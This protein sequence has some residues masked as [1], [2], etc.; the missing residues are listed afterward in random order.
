MP[1][2]A[3][4]AP[5]AIVL[6]LVLLVPLPTAPADPVEGGA[7]R[8]RDA[9]WS[10]TTPADYLLTN[11]VLGGGNAS[12]AS[13]SARITWTT[14]GDFAGNLSSATNVSVAPGGLALTGAPNNLVL[15][16]DFTGPGPWVA[17]GTGNV[18]ASA[19]PPAGRFTAAAGSAPL[20]FDGMNSTAGWIA[21][22]TGPSISLNTTDFIEGAASINVSWSQLAAASYGGA[23][24]T[25]L[26]TGWNFSSYTGLRMRA[27]T[28]EASIAIRVELTDNLSNIW[29][30]TTQ[31]VVPD[32]SAHDF[33]FPPSGLNLLNITNVEVRFRYGIVD[34][35]PH[36][37]NV[38]NLLFY[39]RAQFD[40]S[41]WIAQSVTKPRPTRARAGEVQ[42]TFDLGAAAVENVTAVDLE[43]RLGGFTATLPIPGPLANTTVLDP[44]L[45]VPAPGA[46][47]LSFSLRVQAN[48]LGIAWVD[49]RVDNVDL[50]A[51][52]YW[53]GSYVSTVQDLLTDVRFGTIAANGT[54]GP[55]HGITVHARSG[56]VA[57]PDASWSG[58]TSYPLGAWPAGLPPNR[59]VQLAADLNT[60]GGMQS[61]TLDDLSLTFSWHSVSGT[62]Q[63]LPYTPS[64]VVSRWNNVTWNA[65][66]SPGTAVD[67]LYS[68][69]GVAFNAAVGGLIDAPGTASLWLLAQLTTSNTT[70]TPI[71]HDMT[72]H[73]DTLGPL[74]IITVSPPSWS[75]TADETIQFAATGVDASGNPVPF[76]ANWS[77]DD[78]RGSVSAN[79]TYNPGQAGT[80]TVF[81]SNGTGPVI[82]TAPVTVSPGALFWISIS[83]P[84]ASVVSGSTR[85]FDAYGTDADLNP[86][87]PNP[88]WSTDN[89]GGIITASGQFTACA[90]G[91][92]TVRAEDFPVWQEG[93]VT[94][95][96]GPPATLAVNPL[97]LNL[98]TDEVYLFTATAWDACGNLNTTWVPSWSTSDFFGSI[99]LSGLYRPGEAG[100]QTVTVRSGLLQASA[101]VNVT[102]GNATRIAVSP[103]APLLVTADDTIQFT[104]TGYDA[105]DNPFPFSPVW[106]EDDPHPNGTIDAAG[107]YRPAA[108]GTHTVTARNSNG[109]LVDS[110]AVGVLP[111]AIARL[112]LGPDGGTYPPGS[113]VD[114][115]LSAWDADDNP[116]A[117]TTT[118]WSWTPFVPLCEGCTQTAA[119]LRLRLPATPGPF[120][121][122][123][124]HGPRSVTVT[125]TIGTSALT[126]APLPGLNLTEDQDPVAWDLAAYAG[127]DVTA[128]L[129]WDVAPADPDLATFLSGAFG[130][131][132][133]RVTPKP[134]ASGV[135]TLLLSLR[136]R[137]GDRVNA[138]TTLAITAVNDPPRFD[139]PPACCIQAGTP[140]AFDFSPYVSDIDDTG[141]DLTLTT[142]DTVHASVSGLNVTFAYDNTYLGRTVAV[143]LNVTDGDAW[144]TQAILLNVTEQAPPRRL[145]TLPAVSFPEDSTEVDAFPGTD[146]NGLFSADGALTL[147]FQA[148]A[149]TAV[150]R[151][152]GARL[153]ADLT[154]PADWYGTDVLVIRATDA[155]GCLA[156][157]SAVVVVNPVNDAPRIEPP[158]STLYVRFNQT[159]SFDLEGNITDADNALEELTLTTSDA[160]AW[161][162]G[163]VLTLLYP[164]YTLPPGAFVELPLTLFASDGAALGSAAVTVNISNQS[165]P[166]LTSPFVD[167]FLQENG[168]GGTVVLSAHFDDAEDGPLGLG[169]EVDAGPLGWNLDLLPGQVRLRLSL[170]TGLSGTVPVTITATD[171]S[172]AWARA[173]FRVHIAPVQDPPR[174]LALP[175]IA[176]AA[177]SYTF[178]DL[179]PFVNDS[180]S[181]LA[182]LVVRTSSPYVSAYGLVLLLDYPEGAAAE[183]R[184]T[185][186]L[187]DPDGNEV[188]QVLAVRVTGNVVQGVEIPLA[189]WLGIAGLLS[190]LGAAALL[191]RQPPFQ[192]AFLLAR[193][194]RLLEHRTLRRRADRDEEAH[195]GLI[196]EIREFAAE[197]PE[198][199]AWPLDSD[200]G[201]LLVERHALAILAVL[202]RRA[203][204]KAGSE[205]LGAFL[206]DV[207]DRYGVLL[208]TWSGN[209]EALPGI[210]GMVEGFL[211]ARRYRHGGWE[212]AEKPGER[213]GE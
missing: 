79:G 156:E 84:S 59:Y 184:V 136:S 185:I 149:V 88:A 6:L 154:A 24:R 55:G 150:F 144:A 31:P 142:T 126:I 1:L 176:V 60:T 9:T 145:L 34:G 3:L 74:D 181:D 5:A 23:L 166:R 159:A 94:V 139:P 15:D 91:S 95:T 155:T 36:S 104:A 65:T 8:F 177:G 52:G 19:N 38:D 35:A 101:T 37:A 117:P 210:G 67:L 140:Y 14:G 207:K 108:G 76:T 135:T 127:G 25:S 213:R 205:T 66:L 93:P 152:E 120:A 194:G 99:D 197:L 32:W 42:L 70:L 75:G 163:T 191:L 174:L 89:P 10:F 183:D 21:T 39:T 203:G 83:P 51:P 103:V 69:D 211:R 97:F 204:S 102:A 49:V 81:A 115:L 68:T 112:G 196:A 190:V 151:T 13:S 131:L 17:N 158:F 129:T 162:T 133:V 208:R 4:R 57:A 2:A 121:V 46:Y 28:S 182:S 26:P 212:S 92:W 200:G 125:L 172:G 71:L 20:L 157:A 16:G 111:G 146:L 90:A 122:T 147:T 175:D 178:L 141:S 96:P 12:L 193:D 202:P 40:E 53:N 63:T 168:A 82:G 137:N 100:T 106:S 128:N 33:D 198:G 173:V 54:L 50:R 27:N 192:D 56:P 78:P 130:D 180:D 170:P 201:Q 160:R 22:G 58:W 47:N 134:D 206:D 186:T 161:F 44:S 98:T 80:W 48:T 105:F 116:V 123:A 153:V 138:T 29:T 148:K 199:E 165:P 132:T 86:V 118:T 164:A 119:T 11:A 209:I 73:F 61:P 179:R 167:M 143:G 77:T 187:T 7:G 41:P 45:S 124:M 64:L 30:S 18:S 188:S 62:V 87:S 169:Y 114:F 189:L 113:L 107:L 85:D 110:V 195:A 72:L 43:V 171:T 109:T